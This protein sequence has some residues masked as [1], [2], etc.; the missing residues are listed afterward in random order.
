MANLELLNTLKGFFTSGATPSESDFEQLIDATANASIINSGVVDAAHLPSQLDL[1]QQPSSS[2]SAHAFMGDGAQL[3]NLDANHISQGILNSE[4]LPNHVDLTHPSEAS[5]LRVDTLQTDSVH[6]Q[7]ITTLMIKNKLDNGEVIDVLTFNQGQVSVSV[8]QGDGFIQDGVAT[9]GWVAGQ[10]EEVSGDVANVSSVVDGV[11]N[12]LTAESERAHGAE[13]AIESTLQSEVSARQL[14]D[15]DLETKLTT[16]TQRIDTILDSAGADA[17]SFSEIVNLVNSIDAESDDSLAALNTSVIQNQQAIAT[18]QQAVATVNASLTSTQ[19][20]TNH[21]KD[22]ITHLDNKLTQETARAQD[23][24]GG[25]QNQIDTEKSRVDSFMNDASG[26]S[27]SLQTLGE[28]VNLNQTAISNI[29]ASTNDMGNTVNDLGAQLNAEEQRAQTAENNLQLNMNNVF[30]RANAVE[31]N[32]QGSITGLTARA[33]AAEGALQGHI[34]TEVARAQAAENLLQDNINNESGRAHQ[35]EAALQKSLNHQSQR[36]DGQQ[37]RTD[38]LDNLVRS[39][40]QNVV[41]GKADGSGPIYLNSNSTVLHNL[42]VNQA[43]VPSPG[44][45]SS[46]GISFHNDIGG[47]LGDTAWIRHFVRAGESTTLEI[48]ISNDADDH[49]S[50]N[51]AGNVGVNTHEPLAKFHVNGDALAHAWNTQSDERLKENIQPLRD[52]LTLLNGINGV[53][54]D[55]Q[56]PKQRNDQGPQV[57]VVAQQVESVLP[58]L[59]TQDKNGFKS[60]DYSKLVVPLI[61][62]VKQLNEK[63]EAQNLE[64]KSML[65]KKQ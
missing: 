9:K 57:G 48:G 30:D 65:D 3:E 43:I 26:N 35:Q 8:E 18:N 38:S 60:V 49:I 64:I 39:D 34:N 54:F 42:W 33:D 52:P 37:A 28:R 31:N 27:G 61:E 5:S 12:Q 47:G 16:Q 58:Q 1:T 36:L 62:A 32:L 2:V 7:D 6:C 44:N 15:N 55:W 56:D 25:L 40:N 17:N 11:S 59:V 51:A 50:L 46:N 4:R 19:E 20:T 24:E 14:A 63:V 22:S 53:S 21:L 45:G 29:Q 23:I 13:E 41:L 10:V